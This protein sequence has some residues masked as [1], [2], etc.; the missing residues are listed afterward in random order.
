MENHELY[1]VNPTRIMIE[2]HVTKHNLKVFVK[3][4]LKFSAGRTAIDLQ[5]QIDERRKNP[6]INQPPV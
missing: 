2:D 1:H 6:I 3:K 4:A 5:A